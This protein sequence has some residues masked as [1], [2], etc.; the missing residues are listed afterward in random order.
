MRRT[1]STA[2]HVPLLVS[3]T[4]SSAPPPHADTSCRPSRPNNTAV[5]LPVWPCGR[6]V[7]VGWWVGW[8]VG[9]GVGLGWARVV[10]MVVVVVFLLG[11]G[12]EVAG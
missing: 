5:T 9:L 1:C 4:R 8:G 12:V 10:V 2:V 3:H 7:G 6:M 11:V